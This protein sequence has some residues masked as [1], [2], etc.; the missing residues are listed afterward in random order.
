M[1]RHS[2]H[3]FCLLAIVTL[4]TE[5]ATVNYIS[6]GATW[7]Y[8]LGTEEASSPLDAWRAIGYNDTAWSSGASALGYGH[9]VATT[10]PDPNASPSYSSVY[11]RKTFNVANPADLV[12]LNAVINV[13]DGYVAYINGTE[14][15]RDNVGSGQLFFNDTA[16]A[17]GAPH[18]TAISISNNLSTLLVPG[19]NVLTVHA[20]NAAPNDDMYFDAALSGLTDDQAPMILSRFPEANTL[21]RSLNVIEINFTE[22]VTGVDAGDLRINGTPA[23]DMVSAS[24]SLYQFQFPQPPTGTV[25]ITWTAGHGIQDLANTPNAFVSVNWNYTLDTNFTPNVIIN[26]FLASNSGGDNSLRDDDARDSDWIELYNRGTEAVNLQNWSL[27]DANGS[28]RKYVFPSVTMLP[29]TYLVVIANNPPVN[30]PT[31]LYTGFNLSASGE[32]LGLFDAN[33]NLMSQIPDDFPVTPDYGQQ[34]PDISMG[35]DQTDPNLVGFFNV[36]TPGSAN[37]GQG[38]GFPPEVVFSRDGGTFTNTFSLT[39][40]TP[41]PSAII[42]YVIVKTAGTVATTNI[43]TASSPTYSGPLEI[44]NTCI[45]R[46]RAFYPSGTALPGPSHTECYIRLNSNVAGFTSDLPLIVIHTVSNSTISAGAGGSP[47]T[48]VIFAVFDRNNGVAKLTD[49]PQLIRRAGINLRGSSTQGGNYPRN[50]FAVELLDEFN[51]DADEEVLGMP[52]ESDWVLYAPNHFDK[53]LIHNPVAYQISRDIG[54]YASRTRMVEVFFKDDGGGNGM[55]TAN[56]G[57]TGAGMGDYHGIYVLEEK[58]KR[59]DNRI[60]IERL[61]PFQTNSPNI[62]GGYLVKIDRVDSNERSFTA[63]NQSMVYV[64]PDGL[65]M[66]TA[67][68]AAQA[69]YLTTYFNNFYT[70]LTGVNYTNPVTGYAAWIDVD[71]WIDHQMLGTLTLNADWLRLSGYF[72]KKRGKKIEMGPI[73]DHDRAEG[74]SPGPNQAVDNDWRAFAPRNWIA[75]ASLGGGSDYGTDFFNAGPVF[76]NP[77]YGRLFTDVDFWQK[78]I[79]R[80]AELRR[81]TLDTNNIAAIIDELAEEVRLAQVRELARWGGTGNGSD[82]R[83]RSGIVHNAIAGT[84]LRPGYQAYTNEFDGTYLG[85][86][87]EVAFLKRWW[88]DRINFMDTNLLRSPSLSHSGG[89]VTAGQEVVLVDLSGKAGTT[90]YYTLDGT[91]PRQPGGGIAPGALTYSG[92]ITINN[93]ARIVA[94][95]RNSG[96]S[97]LTGVNNPPR[98]SPWSGP[99]AATYVVATPPLR[100]TEI[101]YHPADPPSGTNDD[102]NFE[103]IEVK[104]VG[105]TPLNLSRFRLTEGVQFEFPSVVLAAGQS[106]VVVA[107]TNAFRSRYGSGPMVLGVYEGRLDNAG[108]RIVLEGSLREPIHDFE[109]K[110]NWYP[111]TD[112]F[113]FSLVIVNDTAPLNTWGLKTSWRASSAQNGSPSAN[114]PAPP[115]IPLVVI[116]EVLTH[117]DLPQVDAIELR[118][119]TGSPANVGGW[120]LTDDFGDPKKFRLTNGTVIAAGGFRAFL[121]GEFNVGPTGFGLSEHG[122]E[123]WLFSGDGVNLTGYAHGFDFGAAENGVS[124]GRHI[125]STGE[126][127]FPPQAGTTLN[128]ANTGPRIGPIVIT[129]IAYHPPPVVTSDENFADEYI[130][131]HNVTG[132][133]VPLYDPAHPTNRWQLRDAVDFVFPHTNMPANSY[134]LVVSFDPADSAALAT[135]RSRVGVAPSVPVFGPFSGRL[136]N[137]EDSVELVK[138]GVPE[139]P[140]PPDFGLVPEILVERVRYRDQLPWPLGADGFGPSLNRITVGAYGNDPANWVAAA[141]TPGGPYAGGVA[142]VITQQ[143]TNQTVV[144]FNAVS[145]TVGVSGTGPFSYQW[146][147]NSNAIPGANSASLSFASVQPSQEGYYSVLVMNSAGS[148]LSDQARLEVLMPAAILQHPRDIGVRGST[149][150]ADFGQSHSN[151][152]FFVAAVSDNPPITYQWRRNGTNLPGANGSSLSINDVAIP[153]EGVYDVRITDQVGSILSD[154]AE[155]IVNVPVVYTS[156]PESQIVAAGEPASLTLEVLGHP[157]PITYRWR[158]G[159]LFVMTNFADSLTSTLFIPN[160]TIGTG[161]VYTCIATNRATPFGPSPGLT[162]SADLVV[163]VPPTNE[164]GIAQG[165]ATLR[166]R[167]SA[168]PTRALAHKWQFNG[169]DIPGATST[170]LVIPN[171]R[172]HHAGL[173][174]YVVTN[175]T[176]R[177]SRAFNAALSVLEPDSDLDGAPDWHEVD[178]GT[179]P[180]DPAS[181]LHISDVG[182]GVS[183]TSLEFLAISNRTYSVQYSTTVDSGNWLKLLDVAAHPTNRLEQVADP[184]GDGTRFYRLIT[185]QAP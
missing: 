20:F 55:V 31:R 54:R 42:R 56:M 146:L 156:H 33:T 181:Y 162:R 135:F 101:M 81:T 145:M 177:Q 80:Y 86:K 110:D 23:V 112:G 138:P 76:A 152:T 88:S 35:R 120:Y 140:G 133:T 154:P 77:W 16:S 62:T 6:S 142:P 153:D 60:D 93:N 168:G 130:E 116:N 24:P 78:W 21:V 44:T 7:K 184:S 160:A 165:T 95:A 118:N 151:I 176:A 149:N 96:H 111:A 40:S 127:H 51:D 64:E 25:S 69:S 104:N 43:P 137:D 91:D 144:G 63:G 97:N 82:T 48:A 159:G 66:V 27:T 174:T 18:V 114:D 98:S 68:R 73:W 103:Y 124:F 169:V 167:A 99:A 58:V 74:T 172:P 28:K 84:G 147:F 166:A 19:V 163:V 121:E 136:N 102:N 46:A 148:L 15:G 39:L 70:V 22:G 50:S 158:S 36:P 65:E 89:P 57:S 109:Y 8:V 123:V 79:D 2:F 155:L 75:S 38:S 115:N 178:A 125:I 119:L 131:L 37:L 185:P 129:E 87:G 47:D 179:N 4:S 122:E 106:A 13:D 105:G 67:Q 134:A 49:E 14:I 157:F 100:I 32:Y 3:L 161:Q 113:G 52:S 182:R 72:H 92:P 94:R 29:N 117:T 71:S 9:A 126:D 1:K 108:E 61:D 183:G 171:L 11:L 139:P 180:N 83:P 10:L 34:Q 5:A 26:E 85:P 90:I 150:L 164:V 173:Y 45:V 128:F 41:D 175:A 59:N 132:A 141:P 12:R 143:P 17:S 107:H 170:N 53:V 30:P